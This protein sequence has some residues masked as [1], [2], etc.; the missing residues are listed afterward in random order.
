[1]RAKQSLP[2]SVGRLYTQ[3]EDAM[4]KPEEDSDQ[5]DPFWT[6]RNGNSGDAKQ[7]VGLKSLV[8]G[9]FSS[10][11]PK[12]NP[13]LPPQFDADGPSSVLIALLPL[14]AP[15]VAFFAYDVVAE[16][17]VKFVD[18]IDY[19]RTWHPA[20]GKAYQVKLCCCS[21]CFFAELSSCWHPASFLR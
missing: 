9:S 16:A 21:A 4:D 1:M 6:L 13:T 15:I 20:D 8:T 10:W 12:S 14:I 19:T 11:S 5:E 2:R 7:S 18:I 17:F 3:L